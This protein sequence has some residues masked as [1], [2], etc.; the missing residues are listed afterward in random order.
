MSSHQLFQSLRKWAAV[1]GRLSNILKCKDFTGESAQK[2]SL[3]MRISPMALFDGPPKSPSEG[4][5]APGPRPEPLG[6]CAPHPAVVRTAATVGR[7]EG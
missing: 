2:T 4:S 1:T 5:R 7:R 3:F 6:P